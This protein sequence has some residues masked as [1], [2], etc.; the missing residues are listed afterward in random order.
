MISA[1]LILVVIKIIIITAT[2]EECLFLYLLWEVV[3]AEH[4]IWQVLCYNVSI[5]I[6]SLLIDTYIEGWGR[7]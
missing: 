2:R 1:Q 4:K 6:V 3:R 7:D 5:N